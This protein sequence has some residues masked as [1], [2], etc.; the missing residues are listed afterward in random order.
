MTS[1]IS[2][3]LTLYFVEGI[4]M[5]NRLG[6]LV[7][8]LENGEWNELIK[9]SRFHYRVGHSCQLLTNDRL[10]ILGGMNYQHQVD[11]LDL[12]SL[13]WSTVLCSYIF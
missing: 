11:V 4:D 9:D 8:R 1:I 13:T 7:Y 2:A 12:K 10:V 6:F 5:D 3:M